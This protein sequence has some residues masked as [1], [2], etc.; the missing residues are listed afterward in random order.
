MLVWTSC[1]PPDCKDDFIDIILD[2]LDEQ[3]TPIADKYDPNNTYP[4]IHNI[5]DYGNGVCVRMR[6]YVCAYMCACMCAH[7]YVCMC[8]IL[9]CV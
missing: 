7:V 2:F 3:I 9:V 8:G 6:V 5:G 1:L 4:F